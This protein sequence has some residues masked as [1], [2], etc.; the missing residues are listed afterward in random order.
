MPQQE[1][2]TSQSTGGADISP[3]P[4]EPVLDDAKV[5]AWQLE[6][7]AVG[8]SVAWMPSMNKR[9][10]VAQGLQYEQC[11]GSAAARSFLV[12]MDVYRQQRQLHTSSR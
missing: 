2:H 3:D 7:N 12:F 1:A 10:S 9:C 4:F 5:E 8:C 6:P 11:A